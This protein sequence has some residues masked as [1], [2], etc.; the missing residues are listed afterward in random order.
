MSYPISLTPGFSLGITGQTNKNH[1][2]GFSPV[3][4][5]LK[6]LTFVETFTPG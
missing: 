6:R 3:G 1:F 2:S 4:K 5:P